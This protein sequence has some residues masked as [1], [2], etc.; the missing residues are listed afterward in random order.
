MALPV[1]TPEQRAQALAKAA[2]ARKYEITVDLPTP[3]GPERTINFM[4]QS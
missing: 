4:S 1:L 2:V 3:P